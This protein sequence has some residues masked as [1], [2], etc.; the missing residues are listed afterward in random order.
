M[1]RV[2]PITLQMNEIEEY[3]VLAETTCLPQGFSGTAWTN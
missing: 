1:K 2:V 3:S